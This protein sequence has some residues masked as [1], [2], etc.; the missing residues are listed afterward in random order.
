MKSSRREI[1]PDVALARL[2][3]LCAR[4]EQCSADMLKKLSTW[5]VPA[6]DA[7]AIM[8]RL[9]EGRFVDDRRF[10]LAYARDKMLFSGWGRYKIMRGLM[11]KRIPRDLID[12]ALESLDPETY[13]ETALRVLRS[14][15]RSI[16]E[17]NTYEGRTKLFR[18]G[19]S[20]GFESELLS[21]LIRSHDLWD[22]EL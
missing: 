20:R 6:A 22:Q 15:A 4:S 16:K 10:A 18:S 17:G 19:A 2:E 7:A 14:K 1:K 11:S 8:R 9:R 5:Q 13:R 21:S 12:E 3:L